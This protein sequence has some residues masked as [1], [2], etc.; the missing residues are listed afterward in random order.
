M[1]FF[2][3]RVTTAAAALLR[4]TMLGGNWDVLIAG[5]TGFARAIRPPN[6]HIAPDAG[7]GLYA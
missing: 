5:S 2:V 1:A 6:L 7:R 4:V 3:K